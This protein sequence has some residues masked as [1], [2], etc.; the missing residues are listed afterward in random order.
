MDTISQIALRVPEPLVELSEQGLATLKRAEQQQAF[1]RAI[2]TKVNNSLKELSGYSKENRPDEHTRTPF[3]FGDISG[4]VESKP[5]S[6]TSY[7]TVFNEFTSYLLHEQ[8]SRAKLVN[9]GKLI[10]DVE[11]MLD[12]STNPTLEQKIYF[13]NEEEILTEAGI[14]DEAPEV[15]TFFADTSNYSNL[16]K[17]NL[18]DRFKA[19]RIDEHL[20]KEYIKPFNQLIEETALD[21]LGLAVENLQETARTTISHGNRAFDVKVI[22]RETVGYSSIL[23]TLF[24]NSVTRSLGR[25][26]ELYSFVDDRVTDV[27]ELKERFA[28]RTRLGTTYVSLNKLAQRVDQ[29]EREHTKTRKRLEWSYNP[30]LEFAA[31]AE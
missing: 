17:G 6:S 24:N 25:S 20:S 18:L 22:S 30:V 10:A 31:I 23:K 12:N 13:D 8:K 9:V 5:T 1:V 7:K 27:D 11:I 26:G 28:A 19:K 29:L 21:H 14:T 16:N 2:H 15:A 3:E 4:R